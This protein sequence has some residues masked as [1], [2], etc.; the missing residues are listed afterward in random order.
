MIDSP[1][2]I[3][4][5]RPTDFDSYARL[6]IGAGKLEPAERR[7]SPQALAEYLCQPICSPERDLFVV[8][9]DREIVGY[10]NITPEIRIGRVVLNYFIHP[11]HRRHRL[12]SKLFGYATK[13]AEELGTKIIH[14]NV[15]QNNA[16]AKN[17]LSRLGF[18]PVR[19]FSQLRLDMAEVRRQD[20]DQE[21]ECCQLQYGEEDRLAQIQNRSF[22]GTWG[23]N[24]NTV[25]QITYW[26]NSSHHSPE[27]V[28]LIYDRDRAIS[29]CWTELACESEVAAG[30]R[31]G[32][33]FMLGVDPDY[34]GR[35]LGK[36]ALLAG[37]SYL[38]AKGV[39]VAEL[40][41]DSE[42]K[43]ACALYHSLGF[44]IWTS[45]LWYEKTID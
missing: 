38:K 15:P 5:Y 19:R 29:Y 1:Y 44:K 11:D 33:I 41:V 43:A 12:A 9:A 45:S 6:R 32:Q 23:Y 26:T 39:Q 16:T 42:N 8:E 27:D 7:I 35:G 24:P 10:M 36:K 34:R 37:L 14:V 22:A 30:E 25:E 17:L 31:R 2:I 28:L 3:R 20:A 21:I 40:T 13:R 18:R 4:N